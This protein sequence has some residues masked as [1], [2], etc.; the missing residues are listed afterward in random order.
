MLNNA[1]FA[2]KFRKNFEE[3]NLYNL[4]KKISHEKFKFFLFSK[5]VACNKQK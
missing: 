3:H 2:Y 4:V 5:S 1:D